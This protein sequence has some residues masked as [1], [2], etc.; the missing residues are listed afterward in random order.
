ME[1]GAPDSPTDD[2]AVTAASG[3][4]T[5]GGNP[6]TP[7]SLCVRRPMIHLVDCRPSFFVLPGIPLL[8]T[9]GVAG[10]GP[11]F[12]DHAESVLVTISVVRRVIISHDV[13]QD[14]RRDRGRAD[15]G[16]AGASAMPRRRTGPG[17]PGRQ[18]ELQRSRP[19]NAEND[20]PTN[21]ARRAGRESMHRWAAWI[22]GALRRPRHGQRVW[23]IT[24]TLN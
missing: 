15:C 2:K 18:G 1:A 23:G 11:P 14:A 19:A 3:R 17:D 12:S 4:R 7:G 24:S 13:V 6:L 20:E 10:T 21:T 22:G 9:G 16:R 8:S 5:V